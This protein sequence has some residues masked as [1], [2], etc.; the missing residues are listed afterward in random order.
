MTVTNLRLQSTGNPS[1]YEV[2]ANHYIVGRIALFKH[3]RGKPWGWIA[4][5]AGGEPVYGFEAS[6]EAAMQAF[7]RCWLRGPECR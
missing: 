3:L 6:R 7:T 4:F 2:I 1:L 5:P